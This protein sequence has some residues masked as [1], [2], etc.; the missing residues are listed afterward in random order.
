MRATRFHVYICV[1]A[2]LVGPSIAACAAI[3]SLGTGS[4][5]NTAE[6]GTLPASDA[7]PEGSV[8][9]ANCGVEQGLNL[10]RSTSK[11][12]TVV[13]DSESHPNCGFRIQG[14]VADLVC[15]CGEQL[16]SM[17][18]F[19]TCAQAQQILVSQTETNVCAQVAEERC[20]ALAPASSSSGSSGA[21][22]CD[23]QCLSECGGGA[24]CA[25][26]CGCP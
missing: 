8:L 6:A 25:S 3:D 14:S 26:M 2:L 5:T 21:P 20:T 24:A 4:G 10:C 16:C 9:G 13:V 15:I 18:A 1:P 12:P 17:G 11:C 22:G 7:G 23:K 19:V